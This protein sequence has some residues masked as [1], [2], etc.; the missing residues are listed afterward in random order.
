M[1]ELVGLTRTRKGSM[2]PEFRTKDEAFEAWIP[3]LISTLAATSARRYQ[4]QASRFLRAW[5][6]EPWELEKE[7]IWR[8]I[9]EFSQGC[10]FFRTNVGKSQT[11]GCMKDLDLVG[12]STKCRSYEPVRVQTVEAHL[13]AVSAFYRF[14][15]QRNMVQVNVVE[16]IKRDWSRQMKHRRRSS[17]RRIPTVDEI[18]ILL[19]RSLPQ[20]AAVYAVMAK[21]GVRI[22][23]ALA[24]KVDS[25]HFEPQKWFVLPQFY[26]KRR[27]NR[28]LP[29]D[30]ELWRLLE[31]YLEWRSE[32]M[33]AN[34]EV[35]DMLFVKA[36]GQAF[37]L[38]FDP[39]GYFSKC[40]KAD[41]ERLGLSDGSNH[42]TAHA[43][44]H[45]FSDELVR[46]GCSDFFW[47]LLRGD[48][49]RNNRDVYLHPTD[50][51]LRRHYLA[52]APRLR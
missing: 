48:V 46:N 11:K 27:G 10:S 49:P 35:H 32:V 14:L 24:L 19:K 5:V 29:I 36:N 1:N 18:Q 22:S 41:Q 8:Y 25:V 45:F 17:A 44:R 51:E 38:G 39:S 12:C 30:A 2:E 33:A 20:R 31:P 47:H 40:I 6:D 9:H 16:A 28:K 23:E 42:F 4:I 13:Q 3:V 21:T 43:F 52:H 50:D 37:S 26:G 15:E 7:D 34:G